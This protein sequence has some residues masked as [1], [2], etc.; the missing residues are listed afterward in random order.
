VSEQRPVGGVAYCTISSANYL[1]RVQALLTSIA[2]CQPDAQ[3]EV[4]LCESPEVCRRISSELNRRFWAP[5]E[6]CPDW[7]HMAF[8]YNVIEFNTALKPYFMERL[9]E[10]GHGGVIYLDPDIEVYSS[11][12]PVGDL[13]KEHDVVLTPHT[14]HPVPD[15]GR[16]PAM[17]EYI[18]AGQFNLGFV[19]IAASENA[20]SMLRWWQE[21]CRERC[22]FDPS[23]RYFVDQF[24]AA[25]FA[26]FAER[27][28]VLRDPGCNVAYWNVFQRTLARNAAG[29]VVDGKPLK[30][31]H[32]SGLA[33]GELTKVSRYQDRVEAPPG[34]FLLDLLKGYAD[35]TASMPWQRY[36]PTPYSFG[37][38]SDGEEISAEDRRNFLYLSSEERKAIRDPFGARQGIRDIVRVDLAGRT[39][40]YLANVKWERHVR[41]A[42]AL[43]TELLHKIRTR[44]VVETGRLIARYLARKLVGGR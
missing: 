5:D 2:A 22:L 20:R 4:L 1:G 14:C 39:R 37:R 40:A 8:Y 7:R 25:A 16:R 12:A 43:G 17:E 26:S 36:G 21:V 30:F 42:M 6:V 35:R 15:D 28:C 3:V 31:F 38:Y 24:W 18:R 27:L 13:L 32:F 10:A 34:S 33:E 41:H 11:L 23:H 29:W 9:I 19:G 44:G